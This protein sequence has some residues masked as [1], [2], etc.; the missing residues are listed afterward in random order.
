MMMPALAAGEPLRLLLSRDG[1]TI[2]LVA[3]VSA[4]GF[5]F[6]ERITHEVK[7]FYK[8]WKT[9]PNRLLWVSEV[10]FGLLVSAAN[11]ARAVIWLGYFLLRNVLGVTPYF[12]WFFFV[13]LILYIVVG[14]LVMCYSKPGSRIRVALLTIGP[15]WLRLLT[16]L[17]DWGYFPFILLFPASLQSLGGPAGLRICFAPLIGVILPVPGGIGETI[18]DAVAITAQTQPSV[19]KEVLKVQ[20]STS[21]PITRGPLKLVYDG[22]SRISGVR[23][24]YWLQSIFLPTNAKPGTLRSWV[25]HHTTHAITPAGTVLEEFVTNYMKEHNLENQMDGRLRAMSAYAIKNSLSGEQM[26][27]LVKQYSLRSAPV[28]TA[29]AA[30]YGAVKFS[31]FIDEGSKDD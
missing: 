15:I 14:G 5:K 25:H 11:P 8:G 23:G 19:I 30:A 21:S 3:A 26:L 7:S 1:P 22:V 4:L 9:A 20:Q 18:A 28:A 12:A 16:V 2:A 10:S 29:A 17:Y 13:N 31:R 27:Q 24:A 6:R